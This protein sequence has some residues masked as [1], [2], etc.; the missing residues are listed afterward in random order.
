MQLLLQAARRRREGLGPCV[1]SDGCCRFIDAHKD[2]H[3][4]DVPPVLRLIP[5]TGPLHHPRSFPKLFSTLQD[6]PSHHRPQAHTPPFPCFSHFP[7]QPSHTQKK[8]KQPFSTTIIIIDGFRRVDGDHPCTCLTPKFSF[9][10]HKQTDQISR[11][12]SKE[13]SVS[14]EGVSGA[15]TVRLLLVSFSSMAASFSAVRAGGMNPPQRTDAAGCT[16]PRRRWRSEVT[17]PP[18]EKNKSAFHRRLSRQRQLPAKEPSLLGLFSSPRGGAIE[19][20]HHKALGSKRESC[21]LTFTNSSMTGSLSAFTPFC[22]TDSDMVGAAVKVFWGHTHTHTQKCSTT[23][24]L[25]RFSRL[26][27]PSPQPDGRFCSPARGRIR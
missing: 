1:S 20:C 23:P 10:F 15:A 6:P 12:H 3:A 11:I 4:N 14:S 16:W 27:R 5:S 21:G 25:A 19:A 7:A 24:E 13:T 26:F 9:R 18:R 22:G 17:S 8:G 2:V